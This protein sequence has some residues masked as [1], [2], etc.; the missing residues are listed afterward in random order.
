MSYR[1]IA[2]HVDAS[3][4]APKR[5]QVA[6]RLARDHDAH[7]IG[8]AALGVSREVFPH[9]YQ[10]APGSLE[11]SYFDPLHA[12][13]MWSLERFAEAAGAA[14]V[15]FEKRLVADLA[16]E[17]LAL[18]GRFADL[19]VVS[20]DD[21]SEALT[22][23]I[24]RIPEYVALTCARPVLV[25]PCAPVS[26]G[27]GRHVLVAWN[28]SKEAAAAL[29]AA[30]PLMR[31]AVRTTVVAFRPRGDCDLGEAAHQADLAAFLSRHEVQ[32]DIL[33]LDRDIDGGQAL[34]TLAAQEAYDLLV[35]GC[36]GHSQFRELILGGVT[37][38]VLQDATLSVLMAR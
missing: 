26:H 31:R 19:V 15:A 17:A 16:S 32:A 36:Y 10:A 18:A 35:I 14:G 25:V 8:V 7:L 4:H 20:Q 27:P 3:R 37:R 12:K 2:V 6:A 24:G 22:D 1:T 33:I 13:A 28:G 23:T 30:L 34:L 21:P 29:S 38:K 11:A 5:I 9:G